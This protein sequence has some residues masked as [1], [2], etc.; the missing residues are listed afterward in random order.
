[1]PSPLSVFERR[2]FS[3]PLG[4]DPGGS[5]GH[6]FRIHQYLA[7]SLWVCLYM[8]IIRY[9]VFWCIWVGPFFGVHVCART[10]NGD[11]SRICPHIFVSTRRIVA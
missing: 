8:R 6:V 4:L 2:S 1:M 11:G 5:R 9:T 3:A 7:V 10:V